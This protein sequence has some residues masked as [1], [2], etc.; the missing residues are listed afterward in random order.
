MRKY[1]LQILCSLL[2][3]LGLSLFLYKYSILKYPISPDSQTDSW[4]VEAHVSFRADGRPVKLSLFVPKSTQEYL[5]MDESFI[6]R[7]FGLTT[8]LSDANRQATWSIRRTAGQHGLYY[9]AVVRRGHVGEIKDRTKA[10]QIISPLFEGAKLEAANSVIAQ[11]RAQSA[12]TSS[13]VE[14]LISKINETPADSNIEL[15]LGRK[16]SS[17]KKVSV[18]NQILSHAGI[19]SRVLFG[20]LLSDEAK[21]APIL[22][23]LEVKDGQAWKA[24]DAVSGERGLPENF[25]PWW[26]GSTDLVEASGVEAL[27]TTVSVVKHQEEALASTLSGVQMTNPE[28]F[29]FS[30][31]SLPLE[32]QSVYRVIMMI[33]IGAFIVALLRNVIGF[34]TFGTFMPVL[35]ALAFR[36][37][38][39]AWGVAFFIILVG[40][41]LIVRFYLETL[42]LL[43]VPRLASVLIAVVLLMAGL[44][45]ITHMLGLEPGLSVSLFP[46]IIMTMTIERMSIMWD[47]VGPYDSV[48]QGLSSILVAALIYGVISNKYVGHLI[49]VFPELLLIVLAST[50]LLGRYTGYR[51]LEIKRFGVLGRA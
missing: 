20:I 44:S 42:K 22:H 37:T 38:Q 51:L 14:G 35:I 34:R 5:I 39:L 25:L 18:A 46:M 9:R 1:H 27:K 3:G 43:L 7:G 26:R 23:R 32:T 29:R 24:Y 48:R 17:L 8:Q 40:V 11:V 49:F 10:P 6:S 4:L 41:G 15:L 2:F 12:D 13:F 36:E 16:P 28:L 31:F 33:P 45:V 50:I 47:E 30:L 21:N 19:L